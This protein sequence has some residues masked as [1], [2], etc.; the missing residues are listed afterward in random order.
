MTP[1]RKR[2]RPRRPVRYLRKWVHQ[3]FFSDSSAAKTILFVFGCQRSGTT[4]FT[5]LFQKDLRSKVYGERGL[6]LDGS[7]DLLPLGDVSKIIQ[8][9][10][11]SLLVAKPLVESQGATDILEYFPTAKSVWMFRNYADVANSS[12]K[13]F[14]RETAMRNLRPFISEQAEQTFAAK[15]AS[16]ETEEIVRR[17][18]SEGM[19]GDDAQI[20]FWY[21]RNILFFDQRLDTHDRVQLCRYEDFVADPARFMQEVYEF[22]ELTFPGAKMTADVHQRSV[23]RNVSLDASPDLVSLCDELQARLIRSAAGQ[24]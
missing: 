5:Q 13:R 19:S 20:L 9:E 14:S 16:R 8:D 4:M 21:V 22:L 12:R 1:T 23:R 3:R 17:H 2:K 6:S 24:S 10:R 18:F 11:A 7:F 15:R